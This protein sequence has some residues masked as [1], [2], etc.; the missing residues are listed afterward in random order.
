[1]SLSVDETVVE[2]TV[3]DS[4]IAVNVVDHPVTIEI[5]GSGPQGARGTQLITGPTPP[6]AETG[7]EGDQ[8]INTSTGFLYG[9]K[10]GTD[11]GVP[12][13]LGTGGGG[14]FTKIAM[15]LGN[16]VTKTYNIAHGLGT[17][18]LVYTVRENSTGDIVY[19][20]ISVDA[21]NISVTFDEAP[22]TNQYRVVV[23]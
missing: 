5:A 23:A 17:A 15:N 14:S 18:D 12:T 22:T 10:T 3:V 2:V 20:G 6:T 13:P 7:M 8:Y 4:T 9:P 1:M 16:G 11:W 21:T 19:P